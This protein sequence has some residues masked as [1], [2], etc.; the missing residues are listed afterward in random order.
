MARGSSLNRLPIAVTGIPAASSSASE[1]AQPGQRRHLDLEPVA[2]QALARRTICFSAPERSSV[3]I[4]C[5]TLS[6]VDR[7]VP[8]LNGE[9]RHDS[10]GSLASFGKSLCA[11]RL[12]TPRPGPGYFR[13]VC[14]HLRRVRLAR[15]GRCCSNGPVSSSSIRRI[16]DPL[17]GSGT[18]VR[19]LI[20]MGAL[21]V[22]VLPAR[23]GS[24]AYLLRARRPDPAEALCGMPSPGTGRAVLPAHVRTRSEASLPDHRGHGSS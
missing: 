14:R 20:A 19:H 22:L 3:G 10:T 13:R 24:R 1:R 16:G 12:E 7:L 23:R 17:E 21:T 6:T 15:R 11:A 5:S 9:R 4:S 8:E 18:V 2:G